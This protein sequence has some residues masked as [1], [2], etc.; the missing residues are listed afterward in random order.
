M[1]GGNYVDETGDGREEAIVAS[2]E[3]VEHT[4]HRFSFI[5][6]FENDL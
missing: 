4:V 2:E 6:L 1:G 3:T 5:A